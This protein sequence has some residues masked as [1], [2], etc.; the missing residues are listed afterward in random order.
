[1]ID[2]T[3]LRAMVAAGAPVE[4]I[5]AAIEADQRSEIERVQARR[6]K[7]AQRQ[8]ARRDAGATISSEMRV[9][10]YE[11]DD[12]RC[13]YCSSEDRLTCDHVVPVK[14]GGETT[15]ENLVTACLSCNSKKQD[16]DR[17]QFERELE[18]ERKSKEV[19][20]QNR[21]EPDSKN[22]SEALTYLLTS[23]SKPLQTKEEERKKVRGVRGKHLLPDDWG[24][25]LS[26]F[27]KGTRPFVERKADDMRD[28][29]KSKAV[30]RADWDATFNGFL[31]RDGKTE[32]VNGTGTSLMDAFDRLDDRAAGAAVND[33]DTLRDITPG[34]DQGR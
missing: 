6:L 3:I 27:A 23:S 19:Q 18:R 25:K 15:L 24:P 2:I 17:K 26:H 12:W 13:V 7:D 33:S 9:E 10:V 16:R 8:S 11:R 1:M 34:G 30:M 31:R 4:A 5:L 14:K 22:T 20:G 21:T 32:H 29:A 28:W